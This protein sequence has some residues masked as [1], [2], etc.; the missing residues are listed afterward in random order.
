MP[1]AVGHVR[2]ARRG[3]P[4]GCRTSRGRR[5][6]PRPCPARA[7]TSLEAPLAR[8]DDERR[9]HPRRDLAAVRV[10]LA[11]DDVAGA[12]VAD[13][14][15]GHQ[16]DRAGAD[17][18]HVLAEDR[19]RERGVDRVAEGVED[20]G[21]LRVDAGPVVPD[22]RR[23]AGRRARRTRRRVR[24]PSPIEFA[25]RCRR[26]ARQWRQRPQTTW[27]SPLTM[28]PSAKSGTL[29]PTSTTSPTNSWP[30]I[31][32]RLDRLRRPGVPRLDV[33]VGAADARLVDPD[34]DVVDA[35]RRAPARRAARGRG[36]PRS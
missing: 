14:R 2:R 18:E 6:S 13:D 35:H 7:W 17:D 5:R 4:P 10:G 20:R 22:V 19:E 8:V 30:T 26:P 33:E 28:S 15:G 32:R 16:A 34:Q 3:A 9:A 23:P 11:D 12:G 31:E 24:R 27:P 29:L 1:A 21:D 25:Q 36:R